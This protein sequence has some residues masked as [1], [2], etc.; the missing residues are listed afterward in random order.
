MII[1]HVNWSNVVNWPNLSVGLNSTWFKV[2]KCFSTR[3]AVA[4]SLGRC[5]R[6]RVSATAAVVF[7]IIVISS[8]FR[9]VFC[10]SFFSWSAWR[11]ANPALHEK[12]VHNQVIMPMKTFNIFSQKVFSKTVWW[13]SRPSIMEVINLNKRSQNEIGI[14]FLHKATIPALFVATRMLN[15]IFLCQDK[16][17]LP[18]ETFFKA[19]IPAASCRNVYSL[20]YLSSSVDARVSKSSYDFWWYSITAFTKSVSCVICSSYF[21]HVQNL[22]RMS[23]MIVQLIKNWII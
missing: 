2:V 10:S 8:P 16:G 11:F 3:S 4:I 14:D 15:A 19:L 13:K 9:L 20:T 22:I 23:N 5:G 17:S 12:W 7:L 21:I 6:E 18:I 1:R